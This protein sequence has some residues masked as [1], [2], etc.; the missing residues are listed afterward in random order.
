MW[1]TAAFVLFGLVVVSLVAV[2][3]LRGAADRRRKLRRG[4]GGT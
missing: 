1:R 2:D 3:V 4:I